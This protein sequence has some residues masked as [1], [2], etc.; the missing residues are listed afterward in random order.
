VGE[1]G[2]KAQ[3]KASRIVSG[4]GFRVA[5]GS[6]VIAGLCGRYFEPGQSFEKEPVPRSGTGSF[7]Q[8]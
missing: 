5:R 8:A 7:V 3:L 4:F 1:K 2:F 6:A